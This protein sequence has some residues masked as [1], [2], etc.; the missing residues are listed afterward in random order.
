VSRDVLRR[1]RA[2]LLVVGLVGT[3]LLVLSLLTPGSAVH[4]DDLDPA[5]ASPQGAQAVARVLASHGVQVSVVR[6]AAQLE[7]AAID[8]DTTLVVTSTDNL[9]VTAARGLRRR[10]S[11]AG[12]LVVAEP[13]RP[14]LRALH[15]P[16][17]R[18]GTLVD[19]PTE[20]AC[21]DPLLGGLTADPGPV[22]GYRGSGQE[23]FPVGR[24][25]HDA[26]AV[27][28]VLGRTPAY[29]LGSADLLSNRGIVHADNAAVALRLLGQRH[30]LVW[31]VADRRDVAMG[32]AGPAEALLP[33]A[34]VP[35]LLLLG[36]AVLATLLWRGRRL[37]PLAVEPLP[38][39][40]K[41]VESTQGRGRLYRHVRDRD[42]V[43]GL[44]R[45]A[46]SRRLGERLRLPRETGADQLVRAVA[47][48]AGRDP[49]EVRALLLTRPVPDDTALTRLA[50]ELAALE[51]ESL[52]P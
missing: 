29:V 49:E 21:E 2:T 44:L 20:S 7:G 51:K 26:A 34:L 18:T 15:L 10:A 28:H 11:A 4:P 16:V 27:V 35:S 48:A 42:H 39:V 46:T 24:A 6:R 38:V 25:P 45:R 19:G 33:R 12:A 30:R 3:G 52:H 31:Y 43:A 41:A 1:H 50:Q 13:G 8:R 14:T 17:T 40:V 22:V 9:G 47:A 23:C 36:V 5:N 32:D 37:G